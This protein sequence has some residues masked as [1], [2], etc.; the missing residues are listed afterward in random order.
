[1]NYKYQIANSKMLNPIPDSEFW[2]FFADCYLEFEI[3][4]LW[5]SNGIWRSA[6]LRESAKA[7]ASFLLSK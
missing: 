4:E 3:C 2:Y 6:I 1:M 7:P 5:T